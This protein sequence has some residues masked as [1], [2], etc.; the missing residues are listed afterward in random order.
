[1]SSA[2]CILSRG[3]ILFGGRRIF[4]QDI[5]TG[6]VSQRFL[7]QSF[8]IQACNMIKLIALLYFMQGRSRALVVV[9]SRLHWAHISRSDT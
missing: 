7:S 6:G 4:R 5:S 3:F 9:T 2:I 1:M 8:L